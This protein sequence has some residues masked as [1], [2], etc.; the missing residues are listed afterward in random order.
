MGAH[1]VLTP[2]SPAQH[3]ASRYKEWA[4]DVLPLGPAGQPDY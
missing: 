4:G 1:A 2:R 3:R